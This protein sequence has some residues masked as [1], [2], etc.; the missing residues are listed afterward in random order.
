MTEMFTE[1]ARPAASVVKPEATRERGQRPPR[2]PGQRKPFR[3]WRL[4]TARAALLL[5]VVGV[6]QLVVSSGA[7]PP[8]LAV[9]PA[10]VSGFLLEAVRSGELVE[11]TAATMYATLIAFVLASVVG[12]VCGISLGLLP[13]TESVVM[14]YLDAVNAMPRIALAPVFIIA[15]GISVTAKI[16]LAFTVVVFILLFNARA[17]IRSAD[18]D[19][20]R[21]SKVLGA[22]KAQLFW[23]VM[24]PV[25]VPSIF[26]GLRLGLIYSL[27]GVVTAEIIASKVGLGQL[28]MQYSGLYRLEGV[29]G[30]L[31]VLAVLGAL[32][33]MLM[34]AAERWILRY[35]PPEDH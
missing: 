29:F 17:G 27:L 18:P 4:F 2:V 21:L 19:V 20:M 33:N 16:A 30:I 8:V 11:A 3:G 24:L 6:W 31:I 14:P 9:Y 23:K 32:I 15:F 13:R 25:A 34:S 5:V 26:A 22:T 35:Q 1:Q 10:D 12:V 7:A 28:I